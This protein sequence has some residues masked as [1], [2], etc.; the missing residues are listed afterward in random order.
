MFSFKEK[1]VF[2]RKPIATSHHF[3]TSSKAAQAQN[4]STSSFLRN[5]YFLKPFLFQISDS[6]QEL[7]RRCQNAKESIF[8]SYW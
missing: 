8:L 1:R 5:L 3:S 2:W 4:F 6:S 7:F